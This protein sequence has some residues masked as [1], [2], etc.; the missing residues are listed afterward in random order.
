MKTNALLTA[1][2]TTELVAGVGLLLVPSTV[3]ELLV[4]QPLSAGAPLVVG[5]VAGTALIAIG[6]ICWLENVRPRPG[7]P[8]GLLIGLLAYNAVVPLLLVH[9][10]TA[11]QTSGIGSWPAVV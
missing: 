1:I 5:R 8:T 3:A 10:Y 9:N 6:L 11:N 2:A 7:S 4:G